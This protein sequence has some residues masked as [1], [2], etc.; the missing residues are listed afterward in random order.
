VTTPARYFGKH[1]GI[2]LILASKSPRRQELMRFITDDFTV[3][4]METDE[5]V[6]PGTPPDEAVCVLARRKAADVAK[7]HPND[8]VIGADTLV[9]CN[10]E[11]LAKP[12][13]EADAFRMIKL[14]C[15]DV[16]SVFTGICVHTPNG[17]YS[18]AEESRVY[19]YDH[20]DDEILRYIAAGESMDK[21]GAY[22]IQCKG[23]LLVRRIEGDYF[24]VMGLPVAKLYRTLKNYKILD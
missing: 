8:I 14:L 18:F 9:Y 5:T 11:T 3:V 12:I 20:S 2:M 10:G 1:G 23:A 19:F 16:H 13:D 24:N 22:G 6:A 15:G 7:L 17:V 21:A 4:T